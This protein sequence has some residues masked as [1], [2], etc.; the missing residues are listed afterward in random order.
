MGN[1]NKKDTPSKAYVSVLDKNG[2][3]SARK[4]VTA[5]ADAAKLKEFGMA[6]RGYMEAEGIKVKNG[7]LYLGF[8]SRMMNG[9]TDERRAN[10][11]KYSNK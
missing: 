2:L 9:N 8:A 11:L 5:I 1:D 10:V 3:L 4:E 7:T 6:D